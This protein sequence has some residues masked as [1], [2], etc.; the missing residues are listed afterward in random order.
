MAKQGSFADMLKEMGV[1]GWIIAALLEEMKDLK[2]KASFNSCGVRKD[3]HTGLRLISRY[4]EILERL[5]RI[6]KIT[7]GKKGSFESTVKVTVESTEQ[8]WNKNLKFQEM[9]EPTE[10][11][12]LT[13]MADA[14]RVAEDGQNVKML[15][16]TGKRKFVCGTGQ[17]G[18]RRSQKRSTFKLSNSMKK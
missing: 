17:K 8:A 18:V 2:G 11:G 16:S 14:T 1:D 13:H 10:K 4:H 7:A 3:G 15:V 12:R 6:D 9:L 5:D